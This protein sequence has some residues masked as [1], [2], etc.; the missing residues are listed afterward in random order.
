MNKQ[1]LIIGIVVLFI[2]VELSGCF[3]GNNKQDD[4]SKFIGTWILVESSFG[5]DNTTEET[6]IFYE[7]KSAKTTIIHF[8]EYPEEPN[9]TININW[10]LFE[11]RGERLYIT[12]K[13]NSTIWYDYLFSNNDTQITLSIPLFASQKYNKTA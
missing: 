7:N 3:E 5:I 13:D 6:W 12:T 11:V 1:M 8:L 4:I 10:V 2:T 9:A